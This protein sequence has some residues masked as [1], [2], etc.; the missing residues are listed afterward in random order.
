MSSKYTPEEEA[1]SQIRVNQWLKDANVSQW[2]QRERE[3]ALKTVKYIMEIQYTERNKAIKLLR[4]F[5][6]NIEQI[7]KQYK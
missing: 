1:D 3:W 7:G 6:I 2:T 5:E 4:Q